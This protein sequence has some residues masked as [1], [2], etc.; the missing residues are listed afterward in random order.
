MN[1]RERYLIEKDFPLSFTA[2]SSGKGVAEYAG[3]NAF[4][5]NGGN[6]NI[7]ANNKNNVYNVRPLSEF[8]EI[9]VWVW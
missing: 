1:C 9:S 5:Y 8:H 4:N 2:I 3:T 7:N 6:G